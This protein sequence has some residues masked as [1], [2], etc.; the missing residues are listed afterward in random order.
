MFDKKLSFT[1]GKSHV[2]KKGKD[3]TIIGYGPILN[4]AFES[5]KLLKEQAK[6]ISIEIIN[7][8]SIKPLDTA[9][10]LKSVKK[11]KRLIVLEDHQKQGGLG[12]AVASLVLSNNLNC[13]FTHL[14]VDNKF[15]QSSKD[16]D[17]L[18]NHFGISLNHL[19]ETIKKII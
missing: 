14:A 6:K 8:S 18:Y 17:E 13:H 19:M 2:L 16:V 5:Q 4:L 9:T 3:L 7:C 15:G 10:I 11:T 1:I 12:E